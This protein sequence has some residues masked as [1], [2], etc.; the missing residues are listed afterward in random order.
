MKKT[1]LTLAVFTFLSGAL[2]MSCNNSAQKVDKAQQNVIEA[3]K[4]LDNANQE[5]QADMKNY[6]M[7][8]AKDIAANDQIIS[9][10][11]AKIVHDQKYAKAEYKK[12]I[13]DFEQK[14]R[15]MKNRLDNYN[16]EGKENWMKF[17]NEFSHDMDELGKSL[18]DFTVK[19]VK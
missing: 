19:N 14:N 4:Q 7:E 10:F 15:E 13:A 3:N 5:Y 16:S 18:K 6:R 11:K 2:F 12:G 17:K 8:T 1:I 9:D